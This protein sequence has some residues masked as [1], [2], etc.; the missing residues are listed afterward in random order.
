MP[1]LRLGKL[2]R[3]SPAAAAAAAAGPA[4]DEQ[5]LCTGGCWSLLPL[6]TKLPLLL[7]ALHLPGACTKLQQAQRTQHAPR[8]ALR[9]QRTHVAFLAA[10]QP[11]LCSLPQR[12]HS[13]NPQ[14]SKGSR[15]AASCCTADAAPWSAGAMPDAAAAAAAAAASERTGMPRML[16]L[17]APPTAVCC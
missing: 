17:V 1:S 10:S 16:L 9:K 2:S 8:W 5:A 11:P 7:L 4:G 12:G 6:L 14:P 13:S 3:P 15:P